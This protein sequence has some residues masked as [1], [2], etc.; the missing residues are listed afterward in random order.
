MVLVEVAFEDVV[1]G[2]CVVIAAASP[3]RRATK[4][5]S[6]ETIFSCQGK[7]VKS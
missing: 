6:L 2:G 5:E 1:V 7:S 3:G 4:R